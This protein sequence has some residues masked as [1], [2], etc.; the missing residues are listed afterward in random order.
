MWA[1]DPALTAE[2]VSSY[3]VAGPAF[4]SVLQALLAAHCALVGDH[5]W[6]ADAT[7]AVLDDPN[8]DFIVVGSGSAGS[9]VANRLSEVPDWKVLLVEAGDNPSLTTEMPQLFYANMN[10]TKDWKYKS[11]PQDT[12]C[13]S[14]K[15]KSCA[16]PRGKTLGGTSSINGM[17]YIRGNKHDYDEWAEQGNRGWSYEEVLPYFKKSENY[18][19]VLTDDLKKYH[20]SGGYLNV[21]NLK[22]DPLED[23]MIKAANELGLK[24]VDINGES[25]IGVMLSF[26][27][28]QNGVRHSTA[29][30]FLSPIK[31][32]KNLHVIKNAYVTKILFEP[33][34]QNV[35]GIV[36]NKEGND[37]IVNA[38]KEVIVSAGAIN[39][40][41]LLLL[42][43]IGPRKHLEDLD[44][45][46]IADLPVGEN[47]QDHVFVPIYYTKEGDKNTMSLPNVIS[48]FAQFMLENRGPFSDTS[49]HRTV[50]FI[51]TINSKSDV[52]DVEH[53]YVIFPPNIQKLLDIYQ[54]HDLS[55]EVLGKFHKISENNFVLLLYTVLLKPKS[56]GRILLQSKDP[57]VYPLIYANF[58]EDPDDLETI[59]N[60]MKQHG[61]K[62]GETKS[63]KEAGFKLEWLDIEPC[64]KYDKISDEFLKCISRELSFSLYHPTSTAKMGPIDDETAV[65][66]PEL[67]VRKV[68]G[69][70]VIDASVMPSIVRG[71]TNAPVI[72]IAEKGA[73]MIKKVW[74][75]THNEL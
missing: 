71:N 75:H 63:F 64:K 39:T 37:I 52:P 55:D 19:G 26:T 41:Q 20:A 45:P 47:L 9:V 23:V 22:A 51:N 17:F 57:N 43:G 35:K 54:K 49:P 18:N 25:Q 12:A 27:T 58:F 30:A 46:V 53:H 5:L 70:R 7:Q 13:R 33:N 21:E 8:Y 44:I 56:K 4:T 60:A 1:C 66:D 11:Q 34:T 74:L 48:A 50:T 68:R 6:P 38:K 31:D 69:L 16:W 29:R 15:H 3:Y 2:I 72:M 24:T 67:K 10:T 32:R 14:Y 61:L 65:V 40:P 59:I 36:I 28:T 73:D 62:L 42:S